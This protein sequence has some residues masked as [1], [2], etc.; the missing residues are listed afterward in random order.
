MLGSLEPIP[1]LLEP[2]PRSLKEDV[3]DQ[4]FSQDFE[5]PNLPQVATQAFA[6]AQNERS[7]SASLAK[8]ICTDQSLAT[9]LLR[10]ANSPAYGG[11]QAIVSLQQAI[12]R[13]GMQTIAELAI[14]I[15]VR[16]SIFPK[17]AFAEVSTNLWTQSLASAL[18]AK[19]IAR[20]QRRN[21]EA[22]YLCGLLHR[23]GMP[24]VLKAV[25]D[26]RKKN[27]T[28]P[29]SEEVVE[30]L[31]SLHLDIGLL[32]AEKW[33]LP[34][35]VAVAIRYSDSYEDAEQ[36]RHLAAVV[37]LS[38]ALAAAL[39]DGNGFEHIADLPVLDELSMYP[40]QLAKVIAHHER[41]GLAVAS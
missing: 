37:N 1:G 6:M 29:S 31:E 15:C 41:I 7:T 28:K 14:T 23:I 10:I 36:H 39:V 38:D 19:E 20:Q 33:H 11:I 35:Q 17:K 12:T 34:S 8:L 2:T 13:L 27:D 32:A 5:M 9:N 30:L 3:R 21:V 40:D 18:F 22:A 4:L 16:G 26:V 25:T 24:L